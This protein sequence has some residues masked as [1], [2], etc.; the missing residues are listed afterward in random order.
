LSW[1]NLKLKVLNELDRLPH[2]FSRSFQDG[3]CV[4]ALVD[5]AGLQ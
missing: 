3:E 5:I 2:G 4:P 1:Q